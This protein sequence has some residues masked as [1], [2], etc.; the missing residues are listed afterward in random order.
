[1]TCK[2]CG[3]AGERWSNALEEMRVCF[4]QTGTEALTDVRV[5]KALGFAVR[6]MA[7]FEDDDE[8][9]GL[10]DALNVLRTAQDQGY[11]LV[12]AA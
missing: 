8:Q 9:P 6:F 3:G 2:Y 12:R 11:R 4:C 7:G 1:M 5:E 10:L